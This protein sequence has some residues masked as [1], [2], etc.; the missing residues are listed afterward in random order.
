MHTNMCMIH[1]CRVYQSGGAGGQ[2]FLDPCQEK[3]IT[4][5]TFP[6]IFNGIIIFFLQDQNSHV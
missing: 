5:L 3:K 2:E 4:H 1:T 6:T